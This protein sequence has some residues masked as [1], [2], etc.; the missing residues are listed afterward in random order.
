MRSNKRFGISSGFLI[1]SWSLSVCV[2]ARA[3]TADIL[4]GKWEWQATCDH[5]EFHGIMEIKQQDTAFTGQFLETNFWDKG[6]ISNGVLNGKNMR[7]D[8]TYGLIQQHL[9]ADLS[10][11]NRKLSGPYESTMFGHC[12]LRGKKL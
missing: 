4:S 8:R 1:A 12:I 5:G 6:T 10:D 11:A 7:F 9:S 2:P 3:E